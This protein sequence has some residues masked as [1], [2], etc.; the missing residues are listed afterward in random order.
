MSPRLAPCSCPAEISRQLLVISGTAWSTMSAGHYRSAGIGS[1]LCTDRLSG[2]DRAGTCRTI[3]GGSLRNLAFMIE[4]SE[5][6][7]LFRGRVERAVRCTCGRGDSIFIRSG[8]VVRAYSI[9]G[10]GSP[11]P[12]ISMTTSLRAG[13][14]EYW[15]LEWL[16]VD[17]E[18]GGIALLN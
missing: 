15:Q 7:L 12:T 14:S 13:T 17:I 10:L 6:S 18:V 9:L 11:Q 4:N 16:T 1:A 3:F 2:P 5:K 8:M